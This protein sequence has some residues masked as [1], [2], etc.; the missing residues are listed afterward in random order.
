MGG[1]VKSSWYALTRL[2][3]GRST[4]PVNCVSHAKSNKGRLICIVRIF[5]HRRKNFILFPHKRSIY[6]FINRHLFTVYI[7]KKIRLWENFCWCGTSHKNVLLM[8]FTKGAGILSKFFLSNGL[9]YSVCTWEIFNPLLTQNI[10]GPGLH[11]FLKCKI[12]LESLGFFSGSLS[13]FSTSDCLNFLF[14]SFFRRP[15][16]IVPCF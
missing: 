4:E 5:F 15:F 3:T 8:S 9:N 2:T 14:F 12:Y 13:N 1:F 7:K 11:T 10:A 16:C 6:L